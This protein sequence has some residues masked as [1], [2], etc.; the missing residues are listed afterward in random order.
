MGGENVSAGSVQ[1]AREPGDPAE[2]VQGLDVEIRAL[3]TPGRDQPIYLI[4]HACPP[5]MS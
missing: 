3:C 5:Y 4:L 2:D 1:V